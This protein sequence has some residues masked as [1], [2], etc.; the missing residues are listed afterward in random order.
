[1]DDL[2]AGPHTS[3]AHEHQARALAWNALK[4]P[5][6]GFRVKFG[7][8]AIPAAFNADDAAGAGAQ[9]FD[10]NRN[11]S[12]AK[13]PTIELHFQTIGH[14]FALSYRPGLR[15]MA[16]IFGQARSRRKTGA[17][18]KAI[19]VFAS[20]PL[21]AKLAGLSGPEPASD[22]PAAFTPFS[23]ACEP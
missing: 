17:M 10:G 1:M 9:A 23:P 2:R 16:D 8:V 3:H 22:E 14:G 7:P 20:M 6:L 5:S 4:R 18:R 15:T 19:I 12:F 21:R 11:A 13:I